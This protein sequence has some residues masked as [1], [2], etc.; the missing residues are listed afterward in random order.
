M[1][2]KSPMFCPFCGFIGQFS[3]RPFEHENGDWQMECGV[4]HALG[5]VGSNSLEAT[6]LWEQRSNTL[7]YLAGKSVEVKAK[8]TPR[9]NTLKNKAT[10]HEG[11]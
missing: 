5:P 4:C 6:V 7:S 8:I 11:S 1:S 2:K 9:T 3:P 10:W